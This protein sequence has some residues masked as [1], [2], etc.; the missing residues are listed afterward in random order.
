MLANLSKITLFALGGAAAY[1]LP[2]VVS[3][4]SAVLTDRR[5]EMMYKLAPPTIV[6]AK[7]VVGDMLKSGKQS[8]GLIPRSRILWGTLAV[9]GFVG[10]VLYYTP[11]YKPL[12]ERVAEITHRVLSVMI[13]YGRV[14]TEAKHIDFKKLFRG[15]ENVTTKPAS[16]KHPHPERARNRAE[17]EAMIKA[18]A[19]TVGYNVFSHQSSNRDVQRGVPGSREYFWMKD[20]SVDANLSTPKE[21]D[22]VAI[23]DT[24]YYMTMPKFLIRNENPVILYTMQ[25][26]K[27]AECND[28]GMTFCFD[29]DNN[30]IVKMAGGADYK[31]MIWNYGVD[32]MTVRSYF[33]W[34]TKNY[35]VEKRF[36]APHHCLVFLIPLAKWSGIWSYLTWFLDSE[37]LERLKPVTGDWAVLENL[38]YDQH[39]VSIAP[40]DSCFSAEVS[41]EMH[42][43]LFHSATASK[44]PISVPMVESQVRSEGLTFAQAAMLCN[45]YKRKIDQ[46]RPTV[47][48]VKYAVKSYQY[49][50]CPADLELDAKEP[51]TAFMSPIIDGAYTPAA[52]AANERQCV[53]ER[54]N[55]L[56]GKEMPLTP[57][58]IQY[59]NEFASFIVPNPGVLVPETEDEV[60]ERQNKPRQRRTLDDAEFIDEPKRVIKSFQKK[61]CYGKITDP[62]NIST[63]N[64]K[65]KLEYSKLMYPFSDL[66]KGCRW[67]AFGQP[68]TRIAERVAEICNTADWVVPSDYTRLDGTVNNLCRHLEEA[69]VLR[70]YHAEYVERVRLAMRTQHHLNGFGT[71]GTKYES[72][73]S[74]LSGS[75]ETSTFNSMDTAFVAYTA[76]RDMGKTPAEAWELLGIFGGDDG[77]T[78]N[79]DLAAYQTAAERMGL[80][81]KAEKILRGRRGVMFLAR[82][83]TSDVWTGE[84][85]S[86]CDIQRQLMKFHT[87]ITLS[88]GVTPEEKLVEKAYSY[89]LTD[90]N[91]P[92]IGPFCCRV[93]EH[94]LTT[95][96]RHDPLDDPLGIRTFSST[97]EEGEQYPN[98]PHDDFMIYALDV[99]PHF[100][101]AAWDAWLASCGD[102][103]AMLSPPLQKEI[104]LSLPGVAVNGEAPPSE[105]LPPVVETTDPPTPAPENKEQKT[106]PIVQIHI[107]NDGSVKPKAKGKP[108]P[109]GDKPQQ[110][111][112]KPKEKPT[113]QPENKDG[114]KKSEKQPKVKGDKTE[115]ESA[116]KEQKPGEKKVRTKRQRG[117]PADPSK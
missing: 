25:P 56:K 86:C 71:F 46:P 79:M 115:K 52:T 65:D 69:V 50:K 100:D 99:V 57:I 42:A 55:K 88:E 108:K 15:L 38:T 102:L 23:I 73:W 95:G 113:P 97:V 75:P 30:I 62:R 4:V 90:K 109:K 81:L 61:E 59:M 66:L 11:L 41:M 22:I 18:L 10:V 116:P 82:K 44:N 47:F 114:K 3:K 43:G 1:Y 19:H 105:P 5:N 12:R 85:T 45:Y 83:Y 16:G 91:T 77:L 36:V 40:V 112:P 106:D 74:R 67:Y 87:T 94:M 17:A 98:E 48:P 53:N 111:K 24:D 63:I 21:R 93:Y 37:V 20:T 31:H 104:I 33:G 96:I 64:G 27:A 89:Y 34:Y 58:L 35:L 103:R 76:Y 68:P 117:K 14:D 54:I 13:S 107:H 49:Y 28:S 39:Y 101:E 70:A 92:I 6:V 7:M 80:T 60:R 84:T 8:L 29:R 78:P 51:L 9:S 26:T 72:D 110:D 2:N 32:V